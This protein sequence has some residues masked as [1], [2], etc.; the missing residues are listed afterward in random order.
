MGAEKSATILWG[1]LSR[2]RNCQ[3]HGSLVVQSLREATSPRCGRETPFLAPTN[4]M[5]ISVSAMP[6]ATISSAPRVRHLD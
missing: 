5:A 6:P 3:R 1:P 2:I 4:T